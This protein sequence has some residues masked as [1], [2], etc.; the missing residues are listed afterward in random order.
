MP[1]SPDDERLLFVNLGVD[2][3]AGSF[4]EPLVAPPDGHTWTVRWSS[5][6][7]M[8]GG[9]GT[10]PILTDAGWRIPGHSAVVLRPAP[11]RRK[12]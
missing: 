8:Y 10:P 4:A 7:P 6:E 3:E 11:A 1:A 2:V 9:Y 12:A 5:A